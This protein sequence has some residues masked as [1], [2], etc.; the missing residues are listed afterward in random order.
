MSNYQEKLVN[1]IST[2]PDSA[3]AIKPLKLHTKYTK[4][5]KTLGGSYALTVIL[6]EKTEYFPPQ[7]FLMKIYGLT[8]DDNNIIQFTN[9][10]S[11][12]KETILPSELINEC[13]NQ[14]VAY[15]VLGKEY[16]LPVINY[17]FYTFSKL[18]EF[19][20][21][22]MPSPDY[23]NMV[24]TLYNFCWSYSKDSYI[25]E[26]D[27]YKRKENYIIKINKKLI[28]ACIMP[29]FEEGFPLCSYI[30]NHGNNE[31]CNLYE[32]KH[33]WI[34]LMLIKAG[35][36]H[37]DPHRG[38]VLV[39]MKGNMKII[40]FGLSLRYRI[41]TE[42][43]MTQAQMM[44]ELLITENT[45]GYSAAKF[46]NYFWLFNMLEETKHMYKSM[47]YYF[48]NYNEYLPPR[49]IENIRKKV[50]SF[51]KFHL[52]QDY[53]YAYKTLQSEHSKKGRQPR[54]VGGDVHVLKPVS[55]FEKEEYYNAVSEVSEDGIITI[56]PTKVLSEELIK[57]KINTFTNEVKNNKELQKN[58]KK[59]LNKVKNDKTIQYRDENDV[60]NSINTYVPVISSGDNVF[61]LNDIIEIPAPVNP[62]NIESQSMSR[63]SQM[64]KKIHNNGSLLRS[65]S[66]GDLDSLLNEESKK[67]PTPTKKHGHN[68]VG[69]KFPS[70]KSSVV[71]VNGGKLRT[72]KRRYKKRN[73]RSKRRKSKVSKRIHIKR[74]NS[75]LKKY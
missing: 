33:F 31:M 42:G 8:Y 34:L 47:S 70:R 43:S 20:Q 73:N 14:N 57:K 26:Y 30:F 17:D 46:A 21:E 32:I 5:Y 50:L 56:K 10:R 68:M 12:I 55:Y 13:E 53:A 75:T 2:A 25:T 49:G 1:K 67:K 24:K 72:K 64:P 7:K 11:E 28:G 22:G 65:K 4:E 52:N 62:L 58:L 59:D 3:D 63:K 66:V 36:F 29:Y 48:N 41:R 23:K 60:I 39:D 38:N 19:L 6:T 37:G 74:R 9:H 69:F 15:N 61:S 16:V 54:Y 44:Q 45:L 40:D 35:I 51:K 27:D 71:P 18:L